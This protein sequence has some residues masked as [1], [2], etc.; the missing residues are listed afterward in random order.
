MSSNKPHVNNYQYGMFS[1]TPMDEEQLKSIN[2][3]PIEIT[4][5]QIR[6]LYTLLYPFI[7]TEFVHRQDLKKWS[8]NILKQ[9]TDMIDAFNNEMNQL[10][11]KLNTHTHTSS[12]PSTPT[13]PPLPPS[14]NTPEMNPWTSKSED[15]DFKH[16]ES[17]ITQTDFEILEMLHR[18]KDMTN[19]LLNTKFDIVEM[20]GEEPPLAIFDLGGGQIDEPDKVFKP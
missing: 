8:D 5:D 6:I 10:I 12:A 9:L 13:S 17:L 16:G 15:S 19:S 3:E 18:L 4:K 7:A 20:I 11:Q 2:R 1:G 14:F